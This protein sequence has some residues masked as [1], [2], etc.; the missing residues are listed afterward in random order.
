[1][2]SPK[3]IAKKLHDAARNT[4]RLVP[5]PVRQGPW[6]FIFTP[7]GAM[8]PVGP[9]PLNILSAKLRG[10]ST[11]DDWC[12]FGALLGAMG[13]P[14]EVM[15]EQL[16]DDDQDQPKGSYYFMWPPETKH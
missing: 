4:D 6:A 10:S 1:M 11:E 9:S 5:K 2:A 14:A 8:S 15:E 13:V 16:A 7:A 3:T 12:F